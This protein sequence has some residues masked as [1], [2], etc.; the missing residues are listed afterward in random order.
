[1]MIGRGTAG[2]DRNLVLILKYARSIT[3]VNQTGVFTMGTFT[4][5]MV[6]G[7]YV[8]I[9]PMF[10]L[11]WPLDQSLVVYLLMFMAAPIYDSS[12]EETLKRLY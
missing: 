1:M 11:N 9:I 3:M 7:L 10:I 12:L 5:T 2:A 4:L 6:A 8:L